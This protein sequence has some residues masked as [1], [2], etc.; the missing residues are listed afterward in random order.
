MQVNN[1]FPTKKT[2]RAGSIEVI[3][4]SMFSGKTEELI[5][6]LKQAPEKQGLVSKYL[7]R[8][9]RYPL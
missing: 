7:A 8:R 2:K 3:C 9:Y 5:K 1:L 4:G 6:R